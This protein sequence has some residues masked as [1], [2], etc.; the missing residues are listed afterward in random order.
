MFNVFTPPPSLSAQVGEVAYTSV[1]IHVLDVNDN[2]PR[3]ERAS[4]AGRVRESAPVGSAVLSAADGHPLVIAAVDTDDNSNGRL[5]YSI[6]ETA[7]RRYI[8]IDRDSGELER[9]RRG[10]GRLRR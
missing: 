2:A 8:T 1:I 9:W 6:V 5:E 4:Y 7:V 3:L 10:D